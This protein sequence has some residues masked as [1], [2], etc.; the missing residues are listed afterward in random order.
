M[1]SDVLAIILER[2]SILGDLFAGLHASIPSLTGESQKSEMMLFQI[3]VLRD[4]SPP[5][6]CGG[7][8]VYWCFWR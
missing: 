6:S 7:S 8:E 4:R 3:E 5:G 2:Q 1:R